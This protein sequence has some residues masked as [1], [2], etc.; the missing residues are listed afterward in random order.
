MG[1]NGSGK[2]TDY[3]STP[4]GSS[5]K[6]DGNKGGTSSDMCTRAVGNINLE[7]IAHCEYYKQK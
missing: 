1:T 7:E 2:F 6:G 5:K 4:N 3:T